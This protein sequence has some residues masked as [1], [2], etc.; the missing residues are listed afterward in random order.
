MRLHKVVFS[1]NLIRK[2]T[3]KTLQSAPSIVMRKDLPVILPSM[4]HDSRAN[5]AEPYSVPPPGAFEYKLV[6]QARI[7]HLFFNVEG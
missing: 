3:E 1:R 7:P 2:V 6:R 5:L 4:S